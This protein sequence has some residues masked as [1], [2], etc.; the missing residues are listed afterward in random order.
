MKKIVK[1]SKSTEKPLS[2]V[3]HRV[4]RK[5]FISDDRFGFFSPVV[6][7]R[8]NTNFLNTNYRLEKNIIRTIS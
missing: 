8:I 3:E 2:V 7:S 4:I 5:N 6:L 1:K